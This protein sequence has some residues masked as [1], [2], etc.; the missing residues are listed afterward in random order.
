M[1]L[2][3]ILL[4]TLLGLSVSTLLF[5]QDA[6]VVHDFGE[7]DFGATVEQVKASEKDSQ[8]IKETPEEIVFNNF[9]DENL[10]HQVTYGFKDGKF[11]GGCVNIVN[12][13]KE[14]VAN[15]IQDFQ[16]LDTVY[17]SMYG[18]PTQQVV[19]TEDKALL[20]DPAKLAAEIM[21]GNVVMTTVWKS[22][23]RTISHVLATNKT[24]ENPEE[25][26]IVAPISHMLLTEIPEEETA[27]AAEGAEA[28]EAEEAEDA[29]DA[30]AEE[31]AE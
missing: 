14:N 16:T 4:S 23:G 22:E 10:K 3:N 18:E 28:E 25:G 19:T 27:E 8:L 9:K 24:I 12:D 30:E 31:A 29:E 1:K 2:K 11:V 21:A 15:Y 17:A 5:A 26:M 7:V 20:E 13:H 6:P